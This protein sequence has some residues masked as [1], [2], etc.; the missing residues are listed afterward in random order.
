MSFILT[1]HQA[2]AIQELNWIELSDHDQESR[3]LY[4]AVGSRRLDRNEADLLFADMDFI[5]ERATDGLHLAEDE[6]ER[7]EL[8]GHRSRIR[9]LKTAG[10][11]GPLAEIHEGSRDRCLRKSTTA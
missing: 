9:S 8:I 1:K 10:Q 2:N 11:D 6:G 3:N 5:I 4:A 7:K